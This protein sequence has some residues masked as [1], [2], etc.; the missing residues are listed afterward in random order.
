[1]DY[2]VTWSNGEEVEYLF[3]P[4][5]SNLEEFLEADKNYI[6]TCLNG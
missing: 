2:L 5:G 6:V 1:M 3:L 4:E